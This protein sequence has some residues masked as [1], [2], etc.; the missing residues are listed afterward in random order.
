MN[1]LIIGTAGHIDHGKSALVKTLTGTDPDRLAEEQER[2][3]TID[4]GFAFLNENIAFIDVPG[5]ERFIKNMVTGAATIDVAML[6]IAADDGVMPQTREHLEILEL[7]NVR[8]GI[9]VINK[10]DLVKSDWLEIVVEDVRQLIK[11]TF[12]EAA[13]VFKT[14][15]IRG[16]GIAELRQYLVELPANLPQT[17][18]TEIFRLPVDRVFTVKGFGTVV[19]G[20]VLSGKINIGDEVEI[21]PTARRAR[22]R[23]IQSQNQVRDVL[24]RGHRAALNLAGIS[25]EEFERGMIV[26]TPGV[27]R[28]TRLLTVFIRLLNDVPVLK[29]NDRVRF[30]LGTGEF[31]VKVRLIGCDCLNPG[32][33]GVAQILFERPVTAGF[34]DHFIIRSYSPL[35]TIGGGIVVDNCP[36]PLRKKDVAIASEITKLLNA[37]LIECLQWFIRR[38]NLRL[39]PLTELAQDITRSVAE[40]LVILKPILESGVL[41]LVNDR[42]IRTD[43]LKTVTG[44][45]LTIL[46]E[47]HRKSPLQAGL[48]K[49]ELVTRLK[50][51]E[52]VSDILITDLQ[53]TGQIKFSNEEIGLNDFTPQINKSQQAKLDAILA[54][55]ERAGLTPPSLAELAG[56]LSI[57]SRE[58][59]QL[60]NL[61]IE[62]NK[63][64]LIE[65]IYPFSV[66]ALAQ[67]EN[68]LIQ[69]LQGKNGATVSELK[70]SLGVSRKY[71][72][73][74]LNYFDQKEV[75]MR[76]GDI[77]RL[78]SFD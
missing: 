27:F 35:N 47:Y 2:G 71:A 5:H 72:V 13:P 17:P 53:K 64:V 55:I 66:L 67:A 29:Y 36:A 21:M 49:S 37:D 73:P 68:R 12:L 78:G 20:T 56:K 75:T 46:N 38:K 59:R 48:E 24:V 18:T 77:R 9:I 54:Q 58:L 52:E 65:R 41:R 34:F 31:I 44:K 11:G 50:L 3:M 30:H 40:I 23:G 74:L 70:E 16:I 26:A 76:V 57:E 60:L 1:A 15:A 32:T 19:T 4:I 43:L 8:Y 69:F 45:M 25:R 33:G 39:I 28:P 14:A 63:I 6:V 22:V 10:I 62:Q 51:P 42:V 61:L 7:L